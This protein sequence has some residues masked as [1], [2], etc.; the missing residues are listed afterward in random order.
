MVINSLWW[1]RIT[2][3]CIRSK[4]D[5]KGT[6]NS[7]LLDF[8]LEAAEEPLT[9]SGKAALWL[10]LWANGLNDGKT[11]DQEA[12][13]ETLRN[14]QCE[15]ELGLN[16]CSCSGEG[17]DRA[18]KWGGSKATG[19]PTGFRVEE[20]EEVKENSLASD[21]RRYLPPYHIVLSALNFGF[22]LPEVGHC[23]F[24]TFPLS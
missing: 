6:C 10:Y 23:C 18:G 4:A 20:E 13:S 11:E 16:Y 12:V 8:I 9:P 24:A 7:K 14:S 17:E 2:W 1:H 21:L 3:L 5:H 22:W 19:W 15:R